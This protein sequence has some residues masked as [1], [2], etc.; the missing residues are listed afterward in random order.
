MWVKLCAVEQVRDDDVVEVAH[1][2]KLYCA[3]RIAGEHYVTDG[4]CTHQVARLAEGFVLD[5]IIECPMHNGRFHIPTGK[6][7]GPPASEPLR[8]YRVRVEQDGLEIWIEAS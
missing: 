7:E 3:Y 8:T 2:G 5:D 4:L 6:V 1:D